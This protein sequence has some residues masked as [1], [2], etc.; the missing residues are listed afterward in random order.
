MTMELQRMQEL[1]GIKSNS[2]GELTLY[3]SYYLENYETPFWV[4]K[5]YSQQVSLSIYK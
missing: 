2:N 4:L 1:A 5:D 3:T